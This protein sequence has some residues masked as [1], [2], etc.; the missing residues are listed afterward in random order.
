VAHR[1]AARLL[2]R[3]PEQPRGARQQHEARG[4]RDVPGLHRVVAVARPPRRAPLQHLTE[5]RRDGTPSA[6]GGF[7][8][9][10][11]IRIVHVHGAETR[12]C[13]P[14]AGSL[15]HWHRVTRRRC[16]ESMSSWMARRSRSAGVTGSSPEAAAF[17]ERHDAHARRHHAGGLRAAASRP[18]VHDVA[19]ACRGHRRQPLGH[20]HQQ[21]PAIAARQQ[22]GCSHGAAGLQRGAEVEAAEQALVVDVQRHAQQGAAGGISDAG[23]PSQ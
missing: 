3:S 6:S 20:R 14:V 12:P 7:A 13:R 22:P 17:V 16:S 18:G 23:W 19:Q 9:L 21:Q 5:A 1:A 8:H 11:S 4:E 2:R 10:R 15:S